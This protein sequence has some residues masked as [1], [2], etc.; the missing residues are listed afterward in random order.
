MDS[1]KEAR[2]ALLFTVQRLALTGECRAAYDAGQSC[3]DP[4]DFSSDENYESAAH[5]KGVERVFC[6][7]VDRGL[8]F[9][10][11]ECAVLVEE[12]HR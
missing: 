12:L 11:A 8:S 1:S 5:A 3:V 6:A 7:L 9:T 10:E 2:R 4:R